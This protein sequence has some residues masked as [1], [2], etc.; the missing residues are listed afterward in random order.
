MVCKVTTIPC[1]SCRRQQKQG[2][3]GDVKTLCTGYKIKKNP[4]KCIEKQSV[5][6]YLRRIK[7]LRNTLQYKSKLK[8]KLF[9]PVDPGTGADGAGA[10][11]DVILLQ[12]GD[13]RFFDQSLV[14]C[15]FLVL[16]VFGADVSDVLVE[17]LAKLFIQR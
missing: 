16:D 17:S 11:D 7:L 14:R 5:V 3:Y 15:N 4:H 12:L 2:A 13:G 1:N 9:S 6:S 10:Q 8:G